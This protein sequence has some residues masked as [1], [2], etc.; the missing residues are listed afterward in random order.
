MRQRV[1]ANAHCVKGQCRI[2]DDEISPAELRKKNL[3]TAKPRSA[4]R[5]RDFTSAKNFI[6]RSQNQQ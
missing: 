3:L 6:R 5:N 2:A 4:G 1:R